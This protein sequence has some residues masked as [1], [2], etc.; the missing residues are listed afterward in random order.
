VFAYWYHSS[1]ALKVFRTVVHSAGGIPAVSFHFL[2]PGA[3]ELR[4][5]VAT[6]K[7]ANIVE[8]DFYVTGNN[9]VFKSSAGSNTIKV[10]RSPVFA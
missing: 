3:A 1:L 8:I 2:C 9:I 5:A 7:I 6:G 10:N 4:A